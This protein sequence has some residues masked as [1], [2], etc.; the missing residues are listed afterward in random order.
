MKNIISL[1][2]FLITLV[3]TNA[4]AYDWQ[5]ETTV[6]LVQPTYMPNVVSFQ[7]NDSAG[8]CNSGAWMSWNAKGSTEM[9]KHSNANAVYS[10]LMAALISG[11]K[12]SVYGNNSNCVVD[13]I[14]MY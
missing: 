2:I 10:T 9:E 4:L 1:I 5:V 6:R 12:V 8:E 3:S 7:L 13:F 14:H 11:K